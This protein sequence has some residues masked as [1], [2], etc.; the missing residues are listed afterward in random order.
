MGQAVRPRVELRIG[1]PCNGR[2]L[3]TAVGV[4]AA[5]AVSAGGRAAVSAGGGGRAEH[6]G[7]GGGVAAHLRLEHLGQRPRRNR[8]RDVVPLDEDSP[9]LP[10][11]QS[12]SRLAPRPVPQ[13]VP[14]R[15]PGDRL[16][17]LLVPTIG[18]PHVGHHF[19]TGHR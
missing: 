8:A 2:R 7:H 4:S 19:V 1:Q 3:G 9:P 15:R 10:R 5:A 17:R 6:Q 12:A 18:G 11:R 16:A 13:V 14:R